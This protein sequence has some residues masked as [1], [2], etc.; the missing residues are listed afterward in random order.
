MMNI[1]CIHI[2]Y[3]PAVKQESLKVYIYIYI[4]IYIEEIYICIHIEVKEEKRLVHAAVEAVE[5][6][7][8]QTAPECMYIL[9]ELHHQNI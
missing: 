7:N 1:L 9:P 4:Y 8:I 5:E 2:I 3:K 6:Y